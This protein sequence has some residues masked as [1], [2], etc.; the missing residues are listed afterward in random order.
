MAKWTDAEKAQLRE[1]Y[2]TLEVPEIAKILNRSSSSI[3]NQVFVMCL[4]R[5][6]EYI[7][8]FKEERNKR[9][10]ANS[11]CFKKGSIPHNK[12]KRLTKEWKAKILK[13]TF[14]KGHQPHNTK[15]N[16]SEA[17]EKG[18]H[19]IKLNDE[20]ILKHH[21]IYEQRHLLIPDNAIII[22]KDKNNENFDIDNLEAITREEQVIR[23]SIYNYPKELIST[24]RLLSK[25][26]KKINE[27]QNN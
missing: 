20:W 16:G 11:G 26:N 19:L 1:L 15:P 22:F 6:D 24:I 14:K 27:K 4:Y 7:A 5:T 3:R 2:K 25:L 18:Y 21:L 13:T 8:K 9:F 23:N 10:L 12:G 17:T